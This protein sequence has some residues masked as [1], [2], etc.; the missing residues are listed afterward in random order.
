M[1]R[2][3]HED[4][5]LYKYECTKHDTCKKYFKKAYSL[6]KHLKRMGDKDYPTNISRFF[7]P[8]IP[9]D[10][11]TIKDYELPPTPPPRIPKDVGLS[12]GVES[13]RRK[14]KAGKKRDKKGTD[15]IQNDPSLSSTNIT[16]PTTVSTTILQEAITSDLK[17]PNTTTQYISGPIKNSITG[18]RG[19]K[20]KVQNITIVQVS[21]QTSASPAA[22]SQLAGSIS[23]PSR[24]SEARRPSIVTG[25]APSNL[26]CSGVVATPTNAIIVHAENVKVEI[27]NQQTQ[28]NTPTS[29]AT[30]AIN[31]AGAVST[32]TVIPIQH[33]NHLL[34]QINNQLFQQQQSPV[35]QTPQVIQQHAHTAV[36]ASQPITEHVWVSGHQVFYNT[37]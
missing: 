24:D 3:M 7:R 2:W 15:N 17:A 27:D 12:E 29:G 5:K 9:P 13:K 36:T 14:K 33:P 30:S 10:Q 20:K 18:K 21:G 8:E 23:L 22:L 28:Q 19:R 6:R 16:T 35:Q 11:E 1:D 31:T 25:Y 26:H 32:A 37:R 4:P 34:H